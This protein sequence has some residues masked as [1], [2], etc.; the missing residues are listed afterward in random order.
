MYHER[1]R[2]TLEPP[3]AADDARRDAI[4]IVDEAAAQRQQ[5]ERHGQP[6]YQPAADGRI[7]A[8]FAVAGA[9]PKPPEAAKARALGD[10][11]ARFGDVRLDG[12]RS[13]RG[14]GYRL[15]EAK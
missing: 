8:G 6:E 11:G 9:V 15:D 13:L 12:V 4:K 1:I 5:H 14:L 10:F 2:S 3:V 7:Q